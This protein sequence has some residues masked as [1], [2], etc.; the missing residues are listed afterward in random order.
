MDLNVLPKAELHC[1]LDGVLDPAMLR[2]IVRHDPAFPVLPEEFER[3]YPVEGLDSFFRWWEFTSAISRKLA[4]C[5]PILDRHLDRLKAQN[6]RYAELM[7]PASRIAR[8]TGQAVE[9]FSR[10]RQWLDHKEAQQIQVEL[11]IGVGRNRS[12]EEFE[13]IAR[14]ILSLYGAGLIVGVALAGPERGWPVLP[15]KSSFA[16]FHE[17][18]LGIEIHAGEWSGPESVWDALDNGYPDRIGHG[19]ALFE[20][21]RLIEVIG[22]RAIHVEMCPTCNLKTGSVAALEQHPVRQARDLGLNFSLNT[23]DPG[24]VG[25]SMQSEYELVA[26]LFGFTESD[27]RQIY[28]HTLQARFQPELDEDV[29]QAGE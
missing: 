26:R 24:V 9:E 14:L 20:D 22:E 3:A 5:Y 29:I 28:A 15:F 8:D 6:V 21:P 7:V 19:V 25:C 17:A 23:D 27:F 11:L 16:R 13:S 18:G 12:A 2:D 1:H 4:Y 10:F